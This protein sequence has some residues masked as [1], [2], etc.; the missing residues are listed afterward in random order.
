[1]MNGAYNKNTLFQ[2]LNLLDC[3]LKGLFWNKFIQ[4]FMSIG[5]VYFFSFKEIH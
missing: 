1:M 3:I 5:I 2:F 4:V